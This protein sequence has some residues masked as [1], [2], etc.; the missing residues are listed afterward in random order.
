[1]TNP[2]KAFFVKAY[3]EQ[4]RLRI[5]RLAKLRSEKLGGVSFKDEAL[6]LC[7]V[8]IDS[9]ASCYYGEAKGR[10]FCRALRELSAN[11]LFGKLHPQVLFDADNAKYWKNATDVK[12]QVEELIKKRAGEMLDESGIAD[13][14]RKSKMSQTQ[15]EALIGNLWRCSIGAICY[16]YMRSAAVHG[17]GTGPLSFGETVY[18]GKKGFRLD[19]DLLYEALQKIGSHVVQVSIEKGEWFGNP[20]Y[21][22]T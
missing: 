22:K 2:D 13:L 3:F 8:Y 21:F 7:L 20:D 9:L 10:T 1:V 17:F 16:S 15:Q 5:E 18:E 4:V 6:I 14:I 12:Q 11:P 19:F